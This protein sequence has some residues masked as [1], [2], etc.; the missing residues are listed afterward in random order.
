MAR[1]RAEPAPKPATSPLP[2]RAELLAKLPAIKYERP[3]KTD[4]DKFEQVHL[5]ASLRLLA[6][7]STENGAAAARAAAQH[8]LGYVPEPDDADLGEQ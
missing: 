6:E 2:S 1:K 7:L 5:A 3:E 4:R 8:L